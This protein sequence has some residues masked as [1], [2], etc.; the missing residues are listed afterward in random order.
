MKLQQ[1]VYFVLYFLQTK[2][3]NNIETM[4]K[5]E[6]RRKANASKLYKK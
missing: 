5:Q 1:Y 2:E 3:Y 4:R 6:N